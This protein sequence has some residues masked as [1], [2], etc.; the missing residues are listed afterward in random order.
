[1]ITG[2]QIRAARALLDM[3][4]DALAEETGLTPQAIR[5]IEN[6]NVQPREGTIADITRAFNGRGVEF[7]ENDGVR[8]FPVGIETFNGHDRFD[9]FSNFMHE[10]L[11]RF[12]GEVCISVTDERILQH[13]WKNIETHRAK[14]IELVKS[15]N[16]S[17][18]ILAVD[19]NFV[20][21]WADLRH[22]ARTPDMPQVSF[23]TFGDNLALISFDNKTQPY[24]VLHKSGPFAAAYKTAFNAAWDKAEVIP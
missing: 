19:G 1:M 3:S 2:R 16:V 14:M 15:K 24:V 21:T 5:K 10:Y 23:F 9:E 18:R 8:C 17:G 11:N 12:G 6:G 13:A 4:Q 7:I 20:R 22:Q